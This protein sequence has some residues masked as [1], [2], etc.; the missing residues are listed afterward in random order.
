LGVRTT[1]PTSTA[2][3]Q[4][5][6][7]ET[8]VTNYGPLAIDYVNLSIPI[9]ANTEYVS[10]ETTSGG[11]WLDGVQFCGLAPLGVGDTATIHERLRVTALRGTIH[12]A[13]TVG[14]GYPAVT[15]VSDPNS[16][17]DSASVDVPIAPVARSRPVH[18]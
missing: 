17:N 8:V 6:E 18:H 10:A 3:G 9:P 15:L 1:G 13:V 14:S 12:Y 5:V 2:A 7:F 11:C 4:I 16:S